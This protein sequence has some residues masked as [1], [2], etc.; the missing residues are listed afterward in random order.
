MQDLKKKKESKNKFIKP[1]LIALLFVKLADWNSACK[2]D[3]Q[4]K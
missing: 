1:F 4:W 3:C 2:F